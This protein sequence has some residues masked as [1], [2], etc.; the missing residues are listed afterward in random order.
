MG[1]GRETTPFVEIHD[2]H[3]SRVA[4]PPMDRGRATTTYLSRVDR[5]GGVLGAKEVL[6]LGPFRSGKR[7]I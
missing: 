5:R 7:Y 2:T 6:K 1:W 4:P 3:M